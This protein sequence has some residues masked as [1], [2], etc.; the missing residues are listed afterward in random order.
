MHKF[1]PTGSI[2]PSRPIISGNG[3]ITENL[4]RYINHHIKH[5]VNQ[6]PAYLEDT[7]DFLRTLDQENKAGIPLENEILVTID[8]SSLY[9]NIPPEEGVEEVRKFLQSRQD[10]SVP[11]EFLTRML[12]QV[13]TLNIFE[14]DKKLFLQK[15][16]TAMG[17]VCAPPFETIFMNK[18]DELIKDLAKTVTNADP[19]GLYKRFLD[20]IFLV[21]KGSVQDLQTFLEEINK[22]HPSIKFTAEFTCHYKCNIVGP[23][24]CFCHQSQSIPFLDTCV[25]IKDGN[26]STDLY[27]KPS[28]RCQYLL[29]SSCQPSHVTKN[30]PY[31]LCYR[32]LRI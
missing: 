15:I 29:P 3:S 17:T 21:W 30:I 22:I 26:F 7:P 24:D 18:I 20:D 10:K 28:D 27:R 31:N 5:F 11:T 8:V 1:H 2:P 4:S 6:I 9:T 23:H 32:L 19:I 16:G 14:F 13:L 12:E 25:S